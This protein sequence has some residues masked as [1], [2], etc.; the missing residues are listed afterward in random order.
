MQARLAATQRREKEVT[1]MEMAFE[2]KVQERMEQFVSFLYR[3]FF[4]MIFFRRCFRYR[5]QEQLKLKAQYREVELAE[6]S[7]KGLHTPSVI[8][9][10]LS[11]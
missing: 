3:F 9:A 6:Q 11:L 5:I 1:N 7:N 8:I 2:N 10:L 4:Y